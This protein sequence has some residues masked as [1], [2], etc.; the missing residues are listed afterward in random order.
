MSVNDRSDDSR[1]LVLVFITRSEWAGAQKVAYELIKGLSDKYRFLVVTQPGGFFVDRVKD[2]S[3]VDVRLL[4]QLTRRIA[5]WK[6]LLVFL[7]LIRIIRQKRPAMMHLH[8]TKAGVLGRIVGWLTG[9]PTLFTVHGWVFSEGVKKTQAMVGASV[10]RVMAKLHGHIICVS[11]YDYRLAC[12]K[13]LRPR[14]KMR[15]IL[16]GVSCDDAPL[17]GAEHREVE[18]LNV[19]MVA[20]FSFPK[21]H[22]LLIRAINEMGVKNVILHLAGEGEN[23][24]RT[25]KL[26][27]SLGMQDQVIFH[28]SVKNI[29]PFY[30]MM[31]A[32][33]LISRF[34]GFPLSLIEGAAMGKPLIA[35]RV[36]G[37]P[38]IVQDGVNGF[39]IGKGDICGLKKAIVRLAKDPKLRKQMGEASRRVYENCCRPERMVAQYQEIYLELIRH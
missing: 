24:V 3:Y 39:L 1:P 36:G 22:E 7:E 11:N 29:Y 17:F 12:R 26:V 30:R 27:E 21:D 34:E 33:A 37:I 14:Y 8:S 2:L 25:Q 9:T 5:I 20:R 15:V 13:G 18:C 32:I 28:G 38:E 10:E 4:T 19:A 6:D 35:S 23:Q 31:D 16:N